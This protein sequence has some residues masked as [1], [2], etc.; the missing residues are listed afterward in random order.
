[1]CIDLDKGLTT[2]NL[3]LSVAIVIRNVLPYNHDHI[4]FYI[5][6]SP[7]S[8]ALGQ[9]GVLQGKRTRIPGTQYSNH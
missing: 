2:F 6:Y 1:M 7:N 5:H 4:S 3:T 9:G 8:P